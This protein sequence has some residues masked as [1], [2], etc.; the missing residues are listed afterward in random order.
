MGIIGIDKVTYIAS[1]KGPLEKLYN[2][3]AEQY[4]MEFN[5][6]TEELLVTEWALSK[7]INKN[8]ICIEP[9][10]YNGKILGIE[11]IKPVSELEIKLI[12][13]NLLSAFSLFK[14]K[15]DRTIMV[16]HTG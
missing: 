10:S 12:K 13:T 6:E 2:E 8:G 15:D 3:F 11:S 9:K 4:S 1:E 16:K 5:L 7:D 14:T